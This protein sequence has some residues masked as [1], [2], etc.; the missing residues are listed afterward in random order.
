MGVPFYRGGEYVPA[1]NADKSGAGHGF[2]SVPVMCMVHEFDVA[3]GP[4]VTR[5]IGGH[6]DPVVVVV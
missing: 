3:L 2:C 5:K 1:F 4:G 6:H